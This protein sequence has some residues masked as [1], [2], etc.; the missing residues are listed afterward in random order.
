[1]ETL[2]IASIHLI[3]AA[4]LSVAVVGFVASIRGAR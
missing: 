2:L 1:M 4:P 3:A